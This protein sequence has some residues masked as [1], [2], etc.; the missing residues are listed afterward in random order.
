MAVREIQGPTAELDE[1]NL[2]LFEVLASREVIQTEAGVG[3]EVLRDL[4]TWIV[5]QLGSL[6]YYLELSFKPRPQESGLEQA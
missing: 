5:W 6:T 3:R 4:G 2:H 1:R